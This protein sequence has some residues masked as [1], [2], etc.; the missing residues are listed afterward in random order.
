M[1]KSK[2]ERLH[3]LVSLIPAAMHDVNVSHRLEFVGNVVEDE[4]SI[5]LDSLVLQGYKE[6]IDKALAKRKEILES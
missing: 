4:R 1:K 3:E 2:A 5:E 6:I